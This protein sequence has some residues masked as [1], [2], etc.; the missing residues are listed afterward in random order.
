V[1]VPAG[2]VGVLTGQVGLYALD[3]PGGW[4]IIGRVT[5]SLFNSHADKPFRLMP[6]DRVRLVPEARR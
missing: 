3:G 1:R 5:V 2:S 4:P 6:G